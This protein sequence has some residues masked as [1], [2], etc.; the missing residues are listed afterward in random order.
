MK[1]CN[2]RHRDEKNDTRDENT[3]VMHFPHEPRACFQP[4][5]QPAISIENIATMF[6]VHPVYPL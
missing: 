1:G 6:F 3:H 5:S 2:Y 4:Y